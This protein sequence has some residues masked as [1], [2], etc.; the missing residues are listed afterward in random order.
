MSGSYFLSF[1]LIQV[2]GLTQLNA[3]LII[4][5]MSVSSMFFSILAA[6]LSKKVP[7]KWLSA[8]GLCLLSLSCFLYSSLTQNSTN[9][10][11]ILRLIVAG[12]G[13]GLS[14]S[15]LMN[16]MIKNVPIDKIGI[17]SGVNNMTRTLG[18]VLGVALFLTIFTSNMTV[19][20]SSAKTSAIDLVQSDTVFEPEAK[21]KL[22]TS[23]KSGS[24]KDTNLSDILENIDA[25]ENMVLK[26]ADAKNQDNIKHSFELQKNETQR[27]W[28]LIQ[29]IFKSHTV[30]TFSFTF[31][32]AALILLPGIFFAFYSDENKKSKLVTEKTF[33]ILD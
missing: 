18:T 8:L 19:Q 24:G 10:E 6:T 16:S 17:T 23:L 3:G 20:M 4:S 32:C 13:M 30:N 5:S 15:T 31:K 21:E 22:I 28:P 33:E 25:K 12:A 7:A 11:I 9:A 2:K 29:D 1:F 26:S 14:M 27:I